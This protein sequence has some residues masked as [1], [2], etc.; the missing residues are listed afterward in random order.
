MSDLNNYLKK[1]CYT[2]TYNEVSSKRS[3]SILLD[4]EMKLVLLK[5]VEENIK[6]SLIKGGKRKKWGYCAQEHD[7]KLVSA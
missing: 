6:Y 1:S 7:T 4:C 5:H 3:E 2:R